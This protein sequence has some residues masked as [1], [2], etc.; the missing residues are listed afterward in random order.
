MLLDGYPTSYL[1]YLKRLSRWTRGDY[2]IIGYMAQKH[3]LNKL[4]RFKILDNI[5]RSLIGITDILNVILLLLLKAF[6][7]THIAMRT[8]N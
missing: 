2:Q 4:S 3:K 7:K 8:Y 1:A 5:R 6:C